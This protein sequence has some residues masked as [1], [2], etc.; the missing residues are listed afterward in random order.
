MDLAVKS[1]SK[2][3]YAARQERLLAEKEIERLAGNLLEY[4]DVDDKVQQLKQLK[5]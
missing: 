4:L 3:T 5:V 2:D 1:V